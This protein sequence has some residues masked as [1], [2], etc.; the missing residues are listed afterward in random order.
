LYRGI[1]ILANC[2]GCSIIGNSI[3]SN[4]YGIDLAHVDDTLIRDNEIRNNTDYGITLFGVCNGTQVH[5]N[6][7]VGNVDFGIRQSSSPDTNATGN[8]WGNE[9]G[10]H[11]WQKNPNGTGDPVSSHVDFQ[12]WLTW[13]AGDFLRW[14][15]DD[16]APEG[17]NGSRE[18]PFNRIQ[19]ALD[20]SRDN[21]TVYVYEG[22]YR[23]SIVLNASVALIGNGT[24]R[25]VIR[26]SAI[27]EGNGSAA[28]TDPDA[29]VITINAT[30]CIRTGFT[31]TNRSS[32]DQRQ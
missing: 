26:P 6:N 5:G 23:E 21:H 28:G 22:E 17:G 32:D 20:L 30:G 1:S 16:D 11:N 13:L 15:V 18:H 10:P 31:V 2:H 29:S 25:S 9:T 14:Y 4:R 3:R 27:E 19:Q 7:I 24:Q 12:P 8:W